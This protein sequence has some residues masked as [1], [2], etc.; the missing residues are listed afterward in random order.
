[1]ENLLKRNKERMEL[2]QAYEEA[3]E[4]LKAIEE[5]LN[6]DVTAERLAYREIMMRIHKWRGIGEQ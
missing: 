1:M 6:L 5:H 2:L 4:Y 3:L